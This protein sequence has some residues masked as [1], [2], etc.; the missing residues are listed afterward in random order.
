MADPELD[1]RQSGAGDPFVNVAVRR[2]RPV[3]APRWKRIL[4]TGLRGVGAAILL[5]AGTVWTIRQQHPTYLKPGQLLHLPAAVVTAQPPKPGFAPS[6]VGAKWAYSTMGWRHVTT[7]GLGISFGWQG[8][9][10]FA[11]QFTQLGGKI[12][13]VLWP[14]LTAADYS[15]YVSAI[16]KNTQAVYAETVG[17]G[18]IAFTMSTWEAASRMLSIRLPPGVN[19]GGVPK[20]WMKQDRQVSTGSRRQWMK[21]AWGNRAASKPRY[22]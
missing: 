22:R 1:Q 18:S 17:S 7:V 2:P 6:T 15:P 14:P 12:D 21:T 13:K 19:G 3:P 10:G 16:P 11:T 8:V 20:F 5:A 9:G 4:K